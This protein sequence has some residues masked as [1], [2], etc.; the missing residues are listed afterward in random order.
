MR[1][2]LK[3]IG[4]QMAWLEDPDPGSVWFIAPSALGNTGY[5]DPILQIEVTRLLDDNAVVWEYSGGT[6]ISSSFQWRRM[7]AQGRL[8]KHEC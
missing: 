7:I 1:G 6:K 3:G 8:I 2:T 5:D 4:R